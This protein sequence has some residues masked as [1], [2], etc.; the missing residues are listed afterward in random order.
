MSGFGDFEQK[1]VMRDATMQLH[2]VNGEVV[3]GPVIGEIIKKYLVPAAVIEG[4]LFTALIF[5]IVFGLGP[6]HIEKHI[7]PVAVA[8]VAAGSLMPM[9]FLGIIALAWKK[10]KE[11]TQ[12]IL[13]P[14]RGI[15][16]KNERNEEIAL[17][18]N[19][20]VEFDCKS[21]TNRDG[22]EIF[23]VAMKHGKD[24]FYIVSGTD[25]HDMEKLCEALQ[26]SCSKN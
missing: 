21:Y 16:V 17:P 20:D 1:R 22:N 14:N 25:Q 4:I 6:E 13:S 10:T 8:L 24:S 5:F 11:Q 12:F 9:F 15:V 3:L 19:A 23:D 26:N 2:E 7:I 18:R